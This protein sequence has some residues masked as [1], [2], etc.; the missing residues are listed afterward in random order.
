MNF[1]EWYEEHV[2][3]M[4]LEDFKPWL[5]EAWDAAVK[6]ERFRVMELCDKYDFNVQALVRKIEEK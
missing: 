4:N 6:V 2:K 5:H 3:Y 1:E